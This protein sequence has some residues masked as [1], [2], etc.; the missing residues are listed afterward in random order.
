MGALVSVDGIKYRLRRHFK[1]TAYDEE[2]IKRGKKEEEITDAEIP[3]AIIKSLSVNAV[4]DL[5]TFLGV[6]MTMLV[7]LSLAG[8]FIWLVYSSYVSLRGDKYLSLNSDDGVCNEVPL[9]V[10]GTYLA[11]RNGYWEGDRHFEYSSA[12]YS[13]QFNRLETNAAEFTRVI[14][15]ALEHLAYFNRIMEKN[16]LAL[17]ILYW[18][19]WTLVSS[20]VTN[21]VNGTEDQSFIADES[22]HYFYL[23]GSISTVF[24]QAN[25]HAS[26]LNNVNGTCE[27][28]TMARYD[29]AASQYRLT[30][31][32]IPYLANEHCM[33]VLDLQAAGY[34]EAA[35]LPEFDIIFDINTVLTCV[36][37]NVGVIQLSV[38]EVVPHSSGIFTLPDGR[39][40]AYGRY[41]YPRFPD[42]DTMYCITDVDTGELVNC[43][44]YHVTLNFLPVFN[45]LGFIDGI[46][47]HSG[48]CSCEG[49]MTAAL[50]QQ[51]NAYSFVT[52]FIFYNYDFLTPEGEFNQEAQTNSQALYMDLNVKYKENLVGLNRDAFEISKDS[53]VRSVNPSQETRNKIY[54]F[55][56]EGLDYGCSILTVTSYSTGEV[57]SISKNYY[58]VPWGH[59]NDTT[60]IS[61]EAR[62]KLYIPPVQLT[63]DYYECKQSSLE[64]FFGAVG[65]SA[66]TALSVKVAMVVTLT[67][68]LAR[69]QIGNKK[70]GT[71]MTYGIDEREEALHF[72]AFKLLAARDNRRLDPRSPTQNNSNGLETSGTDGQRSLIGALAAELSQHLYINRFFPVESPTSGAGE[73]EGAPSKP[74]IT[75]ENIE[76]YGD[77]ELP[78]KGTSTKSDNTSTGQSV[79]ERLRVDNLLKQINERQEAEFQLEKLPNPFFVREK[80]TE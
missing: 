31:D 46:P 10:T 38:L 15:A 12:L 59:C 60:T 8:V 40:F 51:C 34:S 25:S 21:V 32:A 9:E 26:S 48:Y 24:N 53:A 49:N 3:K 30:F 39:R 20:S 66:G 77:V 50:L 64:A 44:L 28:L 57:T 16:N 14:D 41:F 62:E 29:K 13:F 47:G 52:G 35:G 54:E 65:I 27:V 79:A 37:V 74:A 61:N 67:V 18:T 71:Y 76:E 80:K 72:M 56:T 42:M 22:T 63:E 73:M 1:S 19:T 55:C 4:T 69:R 43:G 33:N 36:S 7:Y 75:F 68:L 2:K 11:D 17:T 58:Q 70:T 78:E 45:H 6:R 5:P 23:T